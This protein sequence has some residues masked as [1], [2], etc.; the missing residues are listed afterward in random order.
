MLQQIWQRRVSCKCRLQSTR[1]ASTAPRYPERVFHWRVPCCR[2]RPAA[3][4]S[5]QK[6]RCTSSIVHVRLRHNRLQGA[7]GSGTAFRL[8][9]RPSHRLF[10]W[11]AS[12]RYARQ[13]ST[14]LNPQQSH[15]R[16]PRPGAADML[17]TTRLAPCAQPT[18]CRTLKAH[19]RADTCTPASEFRQVCQKRRRLRGR[20]L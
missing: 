16:S 14:T 18:V 2:H 7:L 5:R 20:A 1:T 10:P 3:G 12:W 8:D 15:R 13:L 4:Q 11:P 6:Y 9:K 19:T 17:C